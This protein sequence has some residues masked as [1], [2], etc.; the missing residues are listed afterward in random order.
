M[1][2]YIDY[3]KKNVFLHINFLFRPTP[4]LANVALGLKDRN[5]LITVNIPDSLLGDHHKLANNSWCPRK[6][7]K[8]TRGFQCSTFI[9]AMWS[10]GLLCTVIVNE[11]WNT[12]KLLLREGDILG[13]KFLV[14][15]QE[16]IKMRKLKPS[17][18]YRIDMNNYLCRIVSWIFHLSFFSSARK[19]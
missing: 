1:K 4:S 16:V 13:V 18:W 2:I 11:S 3:I 14:S 6:I 12:V 8:K 19:I 10:I 5:I 15:R 9:V 7:L 17:R